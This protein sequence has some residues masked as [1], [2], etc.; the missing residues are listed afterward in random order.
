MEAPSSNGNKYLSLQSFLCDVTKN[1][2]VFFY[3]NNAFF[4]VVPRMPLMPSKV[5]SE[6][7]MAAHE[8]EMQP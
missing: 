5:L 3:R 4:G 2:V 7:L 6:H 8:L 1:T